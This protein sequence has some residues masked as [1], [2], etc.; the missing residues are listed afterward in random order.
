MPKILLVC[1][2]R[3]G[4]VFLAS[5]VAAG[6]K[7]T[8]PNIKIDFLVFEGTEKVLEGNPDVNQVICVQEKMPILAHLKFLFDIRAKYDIAV[9]LLPGDRPI[10][11]AL[12][13]GDISIG[14]VS[15]EIKY[16]WKRWLLK[17]YVEP[18]ENPIHTVLEYHRIVEQYHPI[19]LSS[20]QIHW[21]HEDDVYVE[22]CLSENNVNGGYA[23]LHLT[24]K[25]SYKEWPID[26]WRKLASFIEKK[27]LRVILIGMKTATYVE[28]ENFWPAGT[29]NLLDAM[30]LPQVARLVS[31]AQIY[32]GTDTA[33]THI[34]AAT[35]V[36]TVAIFGPSSP[37]IWGPWPNSYSIRKNPWKLKGSQ[38]IGN[39]TLLQNSFRDCVPCLKE[40]CGQHVNSYSDCLR[41][42]DAEEVCSF[43][44]EPLER[45]VSPTC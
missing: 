8:V 3:I 1:P 36:P 16:F 18:S 13:A 28:D 34:A 25:Y 12:F 7:K 26:C 15:R 33:V 24:P 11:Y 4:D 14:V 23:V 2:R 31:G 30:S 35:G 39:V 44:H 21:S 19:E 10:L 22:A 32:V 37:Q 5:S 43:M 29:I 45:S 20:P 27:D 6:L 40:G 42:L 38:V 41:Y 9:S 17:R